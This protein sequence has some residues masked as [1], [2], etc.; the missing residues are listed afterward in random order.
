M[1]APAS[2]YDPLAHQLLR[3]FNAFRSDPVGY[4]G[5][6]G[7]SDSLARE[8]RSFP[9]GGSALA[10]NDALANGARHYANDVGPCDAQ[11]TTQGLNLFST[12][13]PQYVGSYGELNGVV[14]IGESIRAPEMMKELIYRHEFIDEMKNAEFDQAGVACACNPV[15]DLICVIIYGK[16]IEQNVIDLQP[17]AMDY[18]EDVQEC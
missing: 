6:N 10:W 1:N 4:A 17:L 8:A 14:Y 2:G 3:E 13:V 7:F 16:D 12:V 11:I 18:I 15:Q 9:D 5:A